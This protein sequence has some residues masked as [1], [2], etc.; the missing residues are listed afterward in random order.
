MIKTPKNMIEV[1]EYLRDYVV[2]HQIVD[3]V[4]ELDFIAN[5]VKRSGE[6][7]LVP[8]QANKTEIQ[9]L[10]E[11]RDSCPIDWLCEEYNKL[12]EDLGYS[13]PE[14]SAVQ[15]TTAPMDD[16]PRSLP[17][18]KIGDI[19]L[20]QG[21][22]EYRRVLGCIRDEYTEYY[23]IYNYEG[24]VHPD[25]LTLITPEVDVVYS[26]GDTVLYD[27]GD[28]SAV[29]TVNRV[30]TLG[31]CMEH[32]QPLVWIRENSNSSG[33]AAIERAVIASDP[34]LWL[35]NSGGVNLWQSVELVFDAEGLRRGEWS[36]KT[37][38][39]E[40][41]TYTIDKLYGAGIVELRE[42]PGWKISD[43]LLRIVK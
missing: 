17:K 13:Q 10:V 30:Q 27:L 25:R 14:P 21:S 24:Q 40:P 1:V 31:M 29:C 22:S 5:S 11:L 4:A 34:N 43:R 6:W 2:E 32:D 12:L 36:E 39:P 26:V 3:V 28:R 8:Y 15:P 7:P 37:T 16:T 35:V 19:I 20:L 38:A 18:F 33:V 41:Q 42:H 23:T 9:K